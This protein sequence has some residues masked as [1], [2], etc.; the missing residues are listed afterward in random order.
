MILWIAMV[1]HRH[2]APSGH[3]VNSC[4]TAQKSNEKTANRQDSKKKMRRTK[5]ASRLPDLLPARRYERQALNSVRRP[6][7]PGPVLPRLRMLP[8]KLTETQQQAIA[9][10]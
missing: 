7:G 2:S 9:Q 5:Y 1:D 8:S 4:S 6:R 10:C 3:D